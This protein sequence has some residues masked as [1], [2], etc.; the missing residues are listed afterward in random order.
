MFDIGLQELIVIFVLAL[1]VF[2]PKNL[3]QLGRSLGRAMREFR[4]ASE[5]FRSTIETNSHHAPDPVTSVLEPVAAEPAPTAVTTA[6]EGR[7]DTGPR[8]PTPGEVAIATEELGI[9]P[10]P[11][12]RASSTPRPGWAKKAERSGYFTAEARMDL[13]CPSCDPEPA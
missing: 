4:R 1:L 5:E 7:P 3:P 9:L 12:R 8:F 2:G 10:G 6:T 11:A 13:A